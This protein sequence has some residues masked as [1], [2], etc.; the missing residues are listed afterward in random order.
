MVI[1]HSYVSL[2]EGSYQ[3]IIIFYHLWYGHLGTSNDGSPAHPRMKATVESVIDALHVKLTLGLGGEHVARPSKEKHTWQK[4]DWWVQT[5]M[6][7]SGLMTALLDIIET[8]WFSIQ[9]V[10]IVLVKNH[11]TLDP[12]VD[13]FEDSEVI[14]EAATDFVV[15]QFR[16]LLIHGDMEQ[17]FPSLSALLLLLHFCSWD[18]SAGI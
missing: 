17:W 10:Y 9:E 8:L 4:T 14:P 11:G 5:T 2:P 3:M 1:F 18:S 13:R 15:Q 6:T 7:S 16:G 12:Q